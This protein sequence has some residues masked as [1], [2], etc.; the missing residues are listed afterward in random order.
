MIVPTL[1][2]LLIREH[3]YKPIQ[4]K[5]LTLGRQ[6][7]CM[8]YEEVTE[9]F[10]QE[11]YTH[12]QQALERAIIAHDQKTRVGKGTD[13]ITDDVFFGLLGI[14]ELLTMDV[15]HYEK[16]DIVHNLNKPVPESLYGQ[17]DFIVDGGTFDHL[18][19]VRT[20]FE[21]VVRLLKPNGRIFQWNAASN[22]TGAAY[23]SFSPDLFYDYYVLNQ[24]ADCKVYIAEVDKLAQPSEWSF[25]EFEGAE[26]CA[27]FRSNRI[28]V[29]VV[30]AEKSEFS[31]WDKIPVQARYRDAHLWQ[32]YRTAHKVM[33]SS[34]R[35]PWTGSHSGYKLTKTKRAVKASTNSL[36]SLL[37]LKLK[38]K[39]IAWC[40]KR[41]I[42]LLSEH[43]YQYYKLFPC[44]LR[45]KTQIAEGKELKGYRYVGKI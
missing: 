36:I 17:F 6:T 2:R 29:V 33:L 24:F 38:E 16:A 25:Y 8:T 27:H 44:F 9:L 14:K 12:R 43:L 13:Y 32:P 39:G 28:Q 7:I 41:A 31:T 42:S 35:K 3:L 21:N 30:L 11:G 1:A 18:V 37:I 45:R 23:L 26:K 15:S 5:V 34:S 10:Q 22:C 20:A 19:D 4:G 40:F